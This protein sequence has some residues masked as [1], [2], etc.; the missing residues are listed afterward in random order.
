MRGRRSP[1]RD[2]QSRAAEAP[3]PSKRSSAEHWPAALRVV[4]HGSW[5]NLSSRSRWRACLCHS[6][7]YA[8][9]ESVTQTQRRLDKRPVL[10]LVLTGG[11]ARSAYQIGVLRALTEIFPRGRSPF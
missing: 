2:P 4:D 5:T 11:G 8:M 1:L 3:R 6:S 7:V 10:G 9:T